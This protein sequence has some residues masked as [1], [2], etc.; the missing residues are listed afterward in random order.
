[1]ALAVRRQFVDTVR[2]IDFGDRIFVQDSK[3]SVSTLA[4]A[5]IGRAA[6]EVNNVGEI[7][8]ASVKPDSII[9]TFN[10]DET[11][12]FTN[13]LY[14][15]KGELA[16]VRLINYKVEEHVCNREELATIGWYRKSVWTS[17]IIGS[18]V[19]QRRGTTQ[20]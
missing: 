1:M 5:E 10:A 11:W 3:A 18:N 2:E 12:Y 20:R 9:A 16:D 14:V 4:T 15:S 8:F 17:K 13:V 6:I 19:C 7:T